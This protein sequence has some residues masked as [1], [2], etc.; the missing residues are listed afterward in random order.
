MDAAL[1]DDGVTRS[2]T[3]AANY[4]VTR[5]ANGFAASS[6]VT[7]A[8]FIGLCAALGRPQIADDPRFANTP[9]RIANAV[10]MVALLAE[11]SAACSLTDFVARSTEHDVPSSSINSL[12]DLPTDPQV[13]HNEIFVTRV[14]PLAGS[15]REPRSAA[16][17]SATPAQVGRLAPAV[18]EHSDEIVTE[19][20]L[21]TAALRASGAIA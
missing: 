14:H 2:P 20:G 11:A 21:D 17:L 9:T 4:A 15:I 10:E 5:F 1:L 8:E 16:K 13:L 12:D 19:L 18:G 7:D 6:A 3:I